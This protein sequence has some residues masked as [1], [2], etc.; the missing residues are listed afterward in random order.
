MYLVENPI[1]QWELLLNLR[2]KRSFAM[3]FVYQ[4]L[5]AM[6]VLFAWPQDQR[7][8][9]T[10]NPFQARVLVTF[11]FLG[12]FVLT[13]VMAPTFAAGSI[14][15]EKERQTYEMLL[16]SP[17]RP[18]AIVL[19]KLVASLAHLGVLIFSSLPIVMLCL[20]L[21]GV[22]IYEVAGAYLTL[23]MSVLMFGMISIACSSFFKRT[24][25]ALV[26]SYMLILPQ[27]IF[28]AI[29][30]SSLE[31]LGTLRLALM[32]TVVPAVTLAV[33]AI[34]Y[35]LVCHRLLYPPDVGSEGKEVIDLER[36]TQQAVGLVI[37]RDQFPDWLFA[38]AKRDDLMDDHAN[39]VYDKEMRSEIFSQG[40]LML[41]LVIQI[42]MVLA[43]PIMAICL[44][45]YPQYVA[46][47]VG[48]VLSFN[49]LVGPVF[50]A[51]S[52]TSERERETLDLLLTTI[53]SPWQIL[54]GK[55]VAGFRVSAVLTLFLLWPLLLAAILVST[56][57]SNL[58]AVGAYLLIV[59][60]TCVTTAILALFCS[61]LFKKTAHALI[62]AYLVMFLV[63]QVSGGSYILATQLFSE[64]TSA[65]T[66]YLAGMASPHAVAQSIPFQ[67]ETIEREFDAYGQPR[68]FPRDWS[69]FFGFVT[70]TVL[71][72]AVLLGTM[73]WLFNTRWRVAG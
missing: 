23:V 21:G 61:V 16:A 63:N 36:E 19:G 62:A 13:S 68:S 47:Y 56:Y 69:L 34:L 3:L 40:T 70:L 45:I 57:W 54:W 20:P 30:W 43:L 58:P 53:I 48:Y 59:V 37:Q 10:E 66:L 41:R 11:F 6:I 27:V 26:V 49:F 18:G 15:G 51:G 42:S 24:A 5:L 72:N 29:V 44:Y 32:V 28:G 7:L 64:H 12:Q 65:P 67:I 71:Q 60:L 39:P 1:M 52:V 2:R 55:L 8:D 17:L 46:S 31:A 38:P 22:S 33:C 14:T 35:G 4:A 9:L 50:S 25:A 73:V